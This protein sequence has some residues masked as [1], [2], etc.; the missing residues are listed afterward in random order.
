MVCTHSTEFVENP[1]V[2][3]AEAADDDS[4]GL[5]DLVSDKSSDENDGDEDADSDGSPDLVSDDT[6]NDDDNLSC[7][8]SA[9]DCP[10]LESDYSSDDDHPKL[11]I[12]TLAERRA[13]FNA[14]QLKAA[15]EAWR[16]VQNANV[17]QADTV[18]MVMKSPD[19]AACSV[20][21]EAIR[22]T[23]AINV[24]DAAV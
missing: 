9:D 3:E 24:L 19:I 21:R 5:P 20:T 17:G 15:D 23:F 14:R 4:E 10:D 2:R 8:S 12:N 11:T 16:F 13:L 22:D 1:R 7:A 18:E 6:T